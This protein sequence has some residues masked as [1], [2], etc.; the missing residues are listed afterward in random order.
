MLY[1]VGPSWNKR[2]CRE[3]PMSGK[4]LFSYQKRALCS[5][6][7]QKNLV[8]GLEQPC[9][10]NSCQG[11]GCPCQSLGGVST[12]SLPWL[13]FP[14]IFRRFLWMMWSIWLERYSFSILSIPHM[15]WRPG[16]VMQDSFMKVFFQVGFTLSPWWM[17]VSPSRRQFQS[18]VR[19]RILSLWDIKYQRG[20]HFIL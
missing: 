1:E 11:C 3:H 9:R 8:G 14:W 17:S 16:R 18:W 5:C 6:R 12:I 4:A 2:L 13:A 10:P 20:N 19:P 7:C 15:W